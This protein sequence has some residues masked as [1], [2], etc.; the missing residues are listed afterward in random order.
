MSQEEAAEQ[1]QN[2]I[3]AYENGA[4]NRELDGMRQL[5]TM[6]LTTIERLAGTDNT[7]YQQVKIVENKSQ[8]A[9]R[10]TIGIFANEILAVL[11]VLKTDIEAGFIDN[12]VEGIHSEV[13]AD[14][15]ETAGYLLCENQTGY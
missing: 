2:I 8:N 13:F 4:I 7:Y 14:F 1:I 11:K 3:S 12:I 10:M 6:S 5:I 9:H 15:L